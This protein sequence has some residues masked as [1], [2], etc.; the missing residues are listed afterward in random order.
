MALSHSLKP[1]MAAVL[2]KYP[3][4]RNIGILVT[5]TAFAQIVAML[6][7]IV[8]ARL[9]TP[10]VFGQFAVFGSLTAIAITV[11]SIRMD[12]TIM[13]PEDDDSA[14]R[15]AKIATVSNVCV[16]V[17]FALAAAVGQGIVVHFYGDQQLASWLPFGALTIF[18]VAQV[19]VLQ[20]WFNRKSAYRTISVNR[21]QQQIVSS[22]GQLA[23]GL[24][25]VRSLPGLIFGTM[26]GQAGAFL[27]LRLRSKDLV[28]PVAE[29][30][31]TSRELLVRYKKMPLLN[32]P[33]S[34]IDSVRING[35]VLLI[36]SVA[37]GAVGQFN[38]AWRILQVPIGLINSAV[39]Q[40]FFQKL[41]RVQPGEMAPLVRFTILRSFLVATVPFG[42]LYLVAPW[43][44]LVVF[45]AQWDQA[46]GFA[47]ALTPWLMMQL[48]TSPI[49]TVFVVTEKQQWSLIF[50]VF[51]CAAPLSLLYFSPWEL[52]TT[53]R[54]LGFLMGGML[55]VM[56]IL[57]HQAARS[58]DAN[59][60]V[61]KKVLDGKPE[62]SGKPSPEDYVQP[63]DVE[64]NSKE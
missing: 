20:Y 11:A 1:R 57:A 31:P 3:T 58:F 59:P 14:R 61:E 19:T 6:V 5:G 29:G 21:V 34:L 50:A 55:V 24:L 27:N 48:V 44:F 12:M 10:E 26:L 33:T 46:G 30:T 56:L 62:E 53:V 37:L 32:L 15:I 45:G 38:L 9:F 22:G 39:A 17:L 64:G 60:P 43:L 36:G 52:L 63:S 7:S 18:F 51:F 4:L 13:L 41:A 23:F 2:R 40:V 16:S 8:T 35:I 25:G 42:L 49:S 54:I 28:Q 47:R